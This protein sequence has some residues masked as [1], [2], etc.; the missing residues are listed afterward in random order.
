M[1]KHLRQ[2]HNSRQVIQIPAIMATDVDAG[3][4]HV[5]ILLP[6]AVDNF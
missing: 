2:S 4:G 3:I 5:E 1:S 6:C